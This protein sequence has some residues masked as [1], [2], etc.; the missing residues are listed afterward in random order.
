MTHIQIIESGNETGLKYKAT[1]KEWESMLNS[2]GLLKPGEDIE[3]AKKTTAIKLTSHTKEG[4]DDENEEHINIQKDHTPYFV[5]SIMG[6]QSSG[7]STILNLL[8]GCKFDVM[9]HTRG[10]KQVTTGIWIGS[11]PKTKNVLVMDLE[12][13]DSVERKQNRG[14]FERQTSLMALAL[15]EILIVNVWAM[16][17]EEL[18]E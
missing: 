15:S 18:L 7:K 12:G 11:S 5:V 3:S 10:R 2:A 1:E 16:I 9:D 8:F 13:T 6:P 4:P 14:N 17:L